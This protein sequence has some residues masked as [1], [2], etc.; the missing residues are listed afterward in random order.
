MWLIPNLRKHPFLLDLRR[1]GRFAQRNV[2]PYRTLISGITSRGSVAVLVSN[3]IIAQ[4]IPSN[5]DPDV[6]PDVFTTF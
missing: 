5:Y 1:W 3:C 4:N 6:R 2:Y